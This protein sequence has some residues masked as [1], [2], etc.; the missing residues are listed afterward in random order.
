MLS[1]VKTPKFTGLCLALYGVGVVLVVYCGIQI[2]QQDLQYIPVAPFLS[3]VCFMV[4]SIVALLIMSSAVNPEHDYITVD[5]STNKVIP[6]KSV[7]TIRIL[8]AAE[9]VDYTHYIM[10]NIPKE[11]TRTIQVYDDSFGIERVEL[12]FDVESPKDY[13]EYLY[14]R[15]KINKIEDE[16]DFD[17]ELLTMIASDIPRVKDRVQKLLDGTGLKLAEYEA[18]RR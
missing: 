7:K 5:L 15:T 12:K 17:H 10:L 2:K 8:D 4:S 16:A 9:V 18:I 13:G 11:I 6:N 3:G 1:T 14:T